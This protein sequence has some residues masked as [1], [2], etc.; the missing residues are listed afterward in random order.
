MSKKIVVIGAGFGGIIPLTNYI[1]WGALTLC[2][3][4]LYLRMNL[5]FEA[6]KGYKSASLNMLSQTIFFLLI[7]IVG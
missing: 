3:S 5:N 1:T 2:S 7:R 6:E 4:V